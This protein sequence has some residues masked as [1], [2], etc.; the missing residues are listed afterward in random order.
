MFLK[1][2]QVPDF[3]V[4][5]NVDITFDPQ[6]EPRVFPL[7]SQNGGGKSTL[8]QLIFVLLHCAIDPEKFHLVENLLQGFNVA[9]ENEPCSLTSVEIWDDVFG[10]IRLEYLCCS[11]SFLYSAWRN[12]ESRQRLSA[13]SEHHEMSFS[14]YTNVNMF[15]LVRQTTELNL[16]LTKKMNDQA[17]H[18]GATSEH[19]LEE[20]EQML[21]AIEGSLLEQGLTYLGTY[22]I[23]DSGAFLVCRLTVSSQ[24]ASHHVLEKIASKIFLAAP[25]TQVFHF[26][27]LESRK[28]MFSRSQN[29]LNTKSYNADL[30]NLQ[31]SLPNLFTYDFLL[32]DTLVNLFEK[33]RDRDFST[34]IETGRYGN[35]YQETLKSMNSVLI[36]KQVNSRSDLSGVRFYLDENNIELQP[37]DLSHGE[38]KRFSIYMWLSSQDLKDAIV[39]MDEIEIALHPDWQYQIV[40]DLVEWGPTNQYILATHSYELCQAVTPTHVKE[41]TPNFLPQIV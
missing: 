15:E 35:S 21:G 14:E 27:P 39:L 13:S 38:L 29:H 9:N 7:G 5:K 23:K 40:H 41:I 34:V 30:Q 26:L 18:Y 36:G 10:D 16:I 37:E 11:S 19:R 12:S 1:R 3:R 32:V 8:L 17:G 6:L 20:T 31:I 4:L 25:S 28:K 2:I 33:A 22:P 24:A